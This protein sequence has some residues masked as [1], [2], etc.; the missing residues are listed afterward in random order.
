MKKKITVLTLS[1]LLLALSFSASA[2]Q[3]R[4]VFRIGYLANDPALELARAEAIRRTLRDLGYIERQNVA[5]EFRYS[6]GKRDQRALAAELVRLKV[7]LIVAVGQEDIRAAKEATATIPIVMIN[8][9]DPVGSGFV[10]S[11]ARPGGNITGLA[12]LRPP[13]EQPKK[14]EF[15]VNLKTAKQIGLTI[16]PN[17]LS[18]ADRV[19]R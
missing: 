6:E 11:L 8:P 19:I 16:P 1:A 12:M 9:G 7:D 2:Q 15:I 17:V 5:F 3:P 4:K 13:V 18:R 10:E 14:F